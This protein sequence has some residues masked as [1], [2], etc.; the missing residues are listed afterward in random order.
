MK[1]ILTGVIILGICVLS[2]CGKKQT[3]EVT[4]AHSFEWEGSIC[5]GTYTGAMKD[6]RPQGEGEFHG[7]V[8]REKKQQ[9]EVSY[10]GE[11]KQ[12]KLNGEG[13]FTNET[14]KKAYEGQYSKNNRT[15]SFIIRDL[16]DDTYEKVSYK[17]DIPYGISVK[18]NNK[19]QVLDYD[20]YYQGVRISE[21]EEHA[22][23]IPYEELLYQAKEHKKDKIKL[24]CTVQKEEVRE[25]E[26]WTGK[27]KYYAE[28]QVEDEE[29]NPY[30][31]I[32]SLAYEDRKCNYVP[33][34]NSGD[35]ISVYG[36]VGN[37]IDEDQEQTTAIYFTERYPVIEAAYVQKQGRELNLAQLSMNYQDFIDFPY[38]YEEKDI[39][40]EGKVL[41]IGEDDTGIY[42]IL[43]SDSY[44]DGEK[45]KYIC[46]YEDEEESADIKDKYKD[47]PRID[48]VVK[49]SGTLARA[50]YMPQET[51]MTI[52][53]KISIEKLEE[54]Q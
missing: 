37:M 7:Y 2:G 50:Y 10:I 16:Q 32:C 18:Y 12:G 34:L 6:G 47:I 31:L 26:L 40:I 21:L 30:T 54:K 27:I 29:Q 46:Y 51:E 4:V 48:D 23:E 43:E 5:S 19:D 17:K 35:Q 49:V 25:E 22:M 45:R 8:I 52:C 1:K 9:D 15:G 38:E 11:W 13:V 14:Q 44:T 28:I 53:P 41:L 42:L 24:Q 36:F 33:I 20:R 3:T 39:T